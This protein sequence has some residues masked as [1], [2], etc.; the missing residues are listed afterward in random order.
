VSHWIPRAST[1]CAVALF[2]AS[3]L[4]LMTACDEQPAAPTAAAA[5]PVTPLDLDVSG[6][7]A[8]LPWLQGQGAAPTQRADPRAQADLA[9]NT[10]MMASET[11]DAEMAKTAI[12]VAL[13]AYSALPDLGADGLFHVAVLSLAGGDAAGSVAAAEQ[14]LA[15]HDTHLLALG[16]AARA[17]L[18]IDDLVASKAYA[19]RLMAAYDAEQGA[20]P[21]YQEHSALLPIYYAEAQGVLGMNGVP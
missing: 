21:E 16:I 13:A 11:G 1:T 7:Q 15:H 10:A 20:L 12:P 4:S 8:D 3:A 18:A 2:A 6:K 19:Q 5:P 14:I 17:S 9:F